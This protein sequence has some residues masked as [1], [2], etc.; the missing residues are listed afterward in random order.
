L[1][2]LLYLDFHFQISVL[3]FLTTYIISEWARWTA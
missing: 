2:N 1:G 3:N